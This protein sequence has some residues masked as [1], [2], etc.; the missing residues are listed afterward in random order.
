MKRYRSKFKNYHRLLVGFM[1]GLLLAPIFLFAQVAPAERLENEIKLA[2]PFDMQ[3]DVLAYLQDT[4]VENRFVF[5]D[6]RMGGEFNTEQFFDV[7]YDASRLN[8]L[9]DGNGIRY[10]RRYDDG[11]LVSHIVQVKVAGDDTV[12]SEYKFEVVDE[13]LEKRAPDFFKLLVDEDKARFASLMQELDYDDFHVRPMLEL[14][15]TRHRVMLS[16][17]GEPRVTLTLDTVGS[18]KWWIKKQFVE[19]EL[20]LNEVYYTAVDEIERARLAVLIEQI[21][22]DLISEFDMVRD[23]RSKY[24]KMFGELEAVFPL[25]VLW[26]SLRL[27]G[28]M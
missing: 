7:Y 2:V 6:F 23:Q 14:S 21:E 27:I 5:E 13:A 20:E 11:D 15:Q 12:A 25:S 10:R 26:R 24:M 3:E 1:G 16:E 22:R 8:V 18:Q 19:L 28:I 17:H 4:Y 9:D